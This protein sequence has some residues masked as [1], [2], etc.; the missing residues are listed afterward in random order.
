[1]KSVEFN[2]SMNK[3]EIQIKSF[4]NS[5]E[6]NTLSA[7]LMNHRSDLQKKSE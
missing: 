3:N 2:K 5:I 1:M 7:N 6:R 4:S